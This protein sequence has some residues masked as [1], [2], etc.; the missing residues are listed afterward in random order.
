M[1][2][3]YTSG[4]ETD[5]HKH[6]SSRLHE[7]SSN[8]QQQREREYKER[9]ERERLAAQQKALISGQSKVSHGHHRPPVDPKLKPHSRPPSVGSYQT[10]SRTE[11]RDILREASR[12]SPFGLANKEFRDPSRDHGKDS[13]GKDPQVVRSDN[14]KEVQKRDY[15]LKPNVQ[16]DMN[17]LNN[18][19]DSRLNYSA[20]KQRIDPTNR[21]RADPL[22]IPTNKH[23]SLRRHD[24]SKPY[25][26][27][28]D[29]IK[30]HLSASGHDKNNASKSVP[31]QSVG[32]VNVPPKTQHTNGSSNG[33]SCNLPVLNND[34]RI[35]SEPG[36][37]KE[38]IPTPPVIKRPSL[39]SPEK[40]PPRKVIVKCSPNSVKKSNETPTT[41]TALSPLNSPANRR[42]RN[43]SSSS[44]PELRPVMKKID[45]VEGFENLMRDNT[46]GI[47]KIHQIP[48]VMSPSADV[49]KEIIL[50]DI[51]TEITNEAPDMYT[52]NMKPPDSIP[53]LPTDNVNMSNLVNG[54][55]T[56]P[57][58]IS[59]LLKE[60]TSVSHLPVVAV[61]ENSSSL[62]Q[63]APQQIQPEVKEKEHHHHKSKKKNKEKHKHK[64]KE[65]SKEEKEKKKK[66]KDKDR[67]RHKHKEPAV[68][69]PI[70][71][72]IH[73]DK[74][75]PV[76]E[77]STQGPSIG[78]KIKIPKDKIKTES[79]CDLSQPPPPT[80]SL[81]IKIPKEKIN[82]CSTSDSS[83][84][85]RERDR[86]SLSDIPPSKVSKSSH[87]DS[88]Q[89]G[90]HSF[91]KVSN[92]QNKISTH[93]PRF[94]HNLL[95]N[96]IHPRPIYPP[97]QPNLVYYYPQMPPPSLPNMSVPPPTFIYPERGSMYTQYY[98][99]GYMYPPEM[100]PQRPMP[101]TSNPP[102]PKD[103][104]P[105]VPPPPPPE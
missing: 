92:Y 82:N 71:I 74:I 10:N 77:S 1:Y 32:Q 17:S 41:S 38:E 96:H 95:P 48:D 57:T 19:S 7:T 44:E 31:K 47:N 9:K 94:P 81:K 89:N 33:S 34:V 53:P 50:S 52:N 100:Y 28:T 21:S 90:R 40:T 104:P 80:G 72:K 56:N 16:T 83:S 8:S 59:N 26:K 63:I 37:V 30:K 29:N 14:N 24:E 22:K 4:P 36:L 65:K 62:Q 13:T 11:P 58:L 25:L 35:K 67:E 60:T 49:K 12:D 66:H 91:S 99:Q 105:Y 84:K 3:S 86:T 39:F 73:K 23:D 78:L 70:K 87:K 68:T 42:S 20:D 54:L 79:I 51:Q 5:P 2:N 103:A 45:Q 27:E 76:A 15:L 69:E 64:D 43:Y 18:Y 98:H 75:Q 85:K 97:T 6:R 88:K 101:Q 61:V 55:E 93:P 46:I 102:L